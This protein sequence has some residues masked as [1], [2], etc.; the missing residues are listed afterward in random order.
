M[1]RK[2][3]GT[4]KTKKNESDGMKAV[5]VYWTRRREGGAGQTHSFGGLCKLFRVRAGLKLRPHCQLPRG[6]ER[7]GDWRG[8]AMQRDVGRRV[9]EEKGGRP[10]ISVKRLVSRKEERGVEGEERKA[11]LRVRCSKGRGWREMRGDT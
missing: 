6:L 11:V 9:T 1:V 10:T 2:K 8:G 5:N 7:S 4:Y 3:K